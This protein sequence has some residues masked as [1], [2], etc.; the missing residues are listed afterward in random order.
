MI[1]TPRAAAEREVSL[2]NGFS[3]GYADLADILL[4][5][6]VRPALGAA[7]GSFRGRVADYWYHQSAFARQHRDLAQALV[8]SVEREYDPSAGGRH[9]QAAVRGAWMLEVGSFIGNSAVT[10]GR[11][12]IRAKSNLTIVC[13]DTWL[14]DV[15]MWQRKGKWLGTPDRVTGEPRLYEQFMANVQGWNLSGRVLPLR[16]P[17]SV[18]LRYLSSLIDTGQLPSPSLVYVDAA[19]EYPETELDTYHWH[20]VRGLWTPPV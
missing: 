6:G 2:T 9:A 12:A 19:H 20:A 15:G 8:S 11:A 7:G 13:L 14:G 3:A 17:A 1:A 16:A 5:K 18:G 10:W 4:G